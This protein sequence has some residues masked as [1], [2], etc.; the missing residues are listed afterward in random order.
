MSRMAMTIPAITPLLRP[1][2]LLPA[3][4]GSTNE[5]KSIQAKIASNNSY[6]YALVN[7]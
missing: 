2:V 4:G 6:V 1:L 5:H 3:I 7:V